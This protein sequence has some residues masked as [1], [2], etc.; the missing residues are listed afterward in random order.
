MFILKKI[1][2]APHNCA[3]PIRMPTESSVAYVCGALLKLSS[4]GTMVD[5]TAGDKPTQT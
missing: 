1:L 4:D 3:E 5:I 2:N